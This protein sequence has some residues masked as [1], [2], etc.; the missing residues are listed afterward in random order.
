MWNPDIIC[1]QEV[2]KYF[3]VSEIMEK[4]CYVGSYTRRTGDAIDGCAIFWKADKFRLIDE[5]SIKFNMFNLRDNVAQLTV[6]EADVQ[7]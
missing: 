7:R 5:E 3:D 1:L 4:T 2:D 6:L